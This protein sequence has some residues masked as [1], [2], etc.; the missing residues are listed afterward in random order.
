MPTGI[1]AFCA[2]SKKMREDNSPYRF[3]QA[4]CMV[5]RASAT[6]AHGVTGSGSTTVAPDIIQKPIPYALDDPHTAPV[7][8]TSTWSLLY[9]EPTAN[10]STL[11]GIGSENGPRRDEYASVRPAV[12]GALLDLEDFFSLPVA[13]AADCRPT[14]AMLAEC[15]EAVVALSG[16]DRHAILP[17][18][19]DALTG[20]ITDAW[21]VGTSA[22]EPAEGASDDEER[23]AREEHGQAARRAVRLLRRTY[24]LGWHDTDR[25]RP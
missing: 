23:Q 3:V 17:G 25:W 14:M 16:R 10:G 4:S 20:M 6:L 15:A 9:S 12:I 24:G 7:S 13:R 11:P 21:T 2:Y 18:L 8:R 19:V 5:I 22:G 1:V